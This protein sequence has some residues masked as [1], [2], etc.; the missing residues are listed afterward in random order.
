[1]NNEGSTIASSP[2]VENETQISYVLSENVIE[3]SNFGVKIQVPQNWKIDDEYEGVTLRYE[4]ATISI[5]SESINWN[6]A[7]SKQLG[8]TVQPSASRIQ[9]IENLYKGNEESTL[10]S[11]NSKKIDNIW[12]V[13]VDYVY[14]E[15]EYLDYYISN[16]CEDFVLS[17]TSSNGINEEFTNLIEKMLRSMEITRKSVKGNL[18]D[19]KNNVV[20][21]DWL[22]R[23]GV[24]YI[25]IS[26]TSDNITEDY[27]YKYYLEADGFYDIY[28]PPGK[29]H[30]LVAEVDKNEVT[31]DFEVVDSKPSILEIP[32]DDSVEI[33]KNIIIKGD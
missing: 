13:I 6:Y 11:I 12:C 19:E 20:D 10:G 32:N 31:Y 33:T 21:G 28:L 14:D 16:G 27:I 4:N 2:S 7:E 8:M 15:K 25:Y 22:S 17:G 3:F 18:V 26:K 23:D 1:M 5:T 30:V 24:T 29:Y 9:E